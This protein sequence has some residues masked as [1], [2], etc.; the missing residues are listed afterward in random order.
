M[1]ANGKA[2]LIPLF[3]EWIGDSRRT[4]HA[5]CQRMRSPQD[6]EFLERHR[7]FV[8]LQDLIAGGI[9]QLGEIVA[10][11]NSDSPEIS[12]G[13]KQTNSSPEIFKIERGGIPVAENGGRGSELKLQFRVNMRRPV[14][15]RGADQETIG[16][17]VAP[18]ECDVVGVEAFV[19][20]LG[21]ALVV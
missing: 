14:K 11:E 8:V 17:G 16:N 13:P 5:K 4:D 1:I 18:G 12:R 19:V 7:K 10:T 21:I 15:K 9:K 2:N 3:G 6:Q 20:S